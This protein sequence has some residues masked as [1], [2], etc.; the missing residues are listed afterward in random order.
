MRPTRLRILILMGF[1][2][3]LEYR[4]GTDPTEAGSFFRLE[5]TSAPEAGVGAGQADEAMIQLRWPSRP[6]NR[7]RV[8][9]SETLNAEGA[10]WETLEEVVAPD[11]IGVSQ[12]VVSRVGGG[13]VDDD[14]PTT[15]FFRVRLLESSV[16]LPEPDAGEE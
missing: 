15:G 2:S 5:I 10:N 7:Y 6:G 12:I 9:A 16:P 3:R 14:G 13:V 8:E 4:L 1:S 11:G